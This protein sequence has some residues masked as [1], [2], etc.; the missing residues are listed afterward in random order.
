[1]DEIRYDEYNYFAIISF[2]AHML[3]IF[4]RRIC[5]NKNSHVFIIQY[6]ERRSNQQINTMIE[7][8]LF[9]E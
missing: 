6:Q 8:I 5:M 9:Q 7:K 2:E 1:M 4:V 3:L